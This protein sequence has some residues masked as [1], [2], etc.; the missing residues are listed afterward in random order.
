MNTI[1]E[2][3]TIIISKK[4]IANVVTVIL[5]SDNILEVK[6]DE[7]LTEIEK[8]HIIQVRS[9]VEELGKGKKMLTYFDTYNFMSINSEAREY[10]GT[11]EA[12][13]FT[14][15]NAVLIDSLPKK[16]LFNFVLRINKP[17]VPTK[18]FSSKD[19]AM[20]WLKEWQF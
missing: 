6:W 5:N 9:L 8:T 2:H 20:N 3:K 18:G 11:K 17:A 7:L 12:S 19:D 4:E 14:L 1:S 15:A 16:I 10:A 13:D